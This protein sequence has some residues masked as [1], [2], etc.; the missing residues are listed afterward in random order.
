MLVKKYFGKTTRDALR[1]VREELGAD[2]L[3]LSNRPLP[4]GGIEI[5]AVA[6]NDVSALAHSLTGAATARHTPQMPPAGISGGQNAAFP[7]PALQNPTPAR[8]AVMNNALARTYAVPVEPLDEPAPPPSPMRPMTPPQNS[9]PVPEDM[10]RMAAE[11]SQNPETFAQVTQATFPT[12]PAQPAPARA[13]SAIDKLEKMT[14]LDTPTKLEA[15]PPAPEEAD[16]VDDAPNGNKTLPRRISPLQDDPATPSM[17]D[18]ALARLDT[19]GNEIKLLRG[20]LQGQMAS[21]AWANFEDKEPVQAELFR[22]LLSAGMS[23]A[24]CRQ[25]IAKLPTNFNDEAALKWAKSALAHNITTLNEKED[26]VAKGGLFALVGP[27]GIG[28]TTTVAKL[29]ARC[30]IRHG[31]DKVALITTDSYRIGAQDQLRLYGKILGVSVYSVQNE[32]D[33]NLTLADLGDK[34]H[35]VLIDAV[36]M[37]QRDSRVNG[38]IEMFS[39]SVARGGHTIQRLLTLAANAD[40]H[41]LEDVVR[42]YRGTGLAGCII[43]KLDEA[44][45][46]G[47]VLDIL[48]RHRLPLYYVTNGQKVPEDLHLPNAQFLVDRAFKSREA[49]PYSFKRDEYQ[50]LQAAQA[51][52]AGWS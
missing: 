28:K 4:T 41:T 51:G 36:G 43:S 32:T 20:I 18:P 29:A 30:T 7:N 26:V 48:I 21:L 14:T 40:G 35:V 11:L 22:Q 45:S 39:N 42:R 49:G 19:L 1:Q 15:K 25:L 52:Q 24:L 2:A 5:M 44:V 31:A 6:D 46:V 10:A 3:I 9:M 13:E 34:H 8:S 33:L 12:V 38:Q 17:D 47:P 27:T 37:S 50:M 16:M 23:P